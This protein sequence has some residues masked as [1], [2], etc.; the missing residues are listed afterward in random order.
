MKTIF[1]RTYGSLACFLL[2]AVSC[3]RSNDG[4]TT[5]FPPDFNSFSDSQMVEFVMKNASPDSV[6]RFI[7][8]SALG[9]VTEGR[10]DTLAIAAAYAYE[11][12]ADSALMA[13][14]KEFDSFSST[15]PLA[16]KMKIYAMAGELDPQRL[17]YQLGLEYVSHIRDSK[18]T[19]DD[20][21]AEISAFKKAC[22][23]DSITYIRF[24]KG[25]RTVLRA[26]HGKDLPEAIY[27]A[28]AEQ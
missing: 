19:V 5:S 18:M 15:L 6:A 27:K 25:F 16:D 17:G 20:V 11:H 1:A 12:Y 3:G 22:A 9:K 10:I 21:R 7:C 4:E 23:D 24:M 13:F 26:D 28:F 2:A 14:S 8:N